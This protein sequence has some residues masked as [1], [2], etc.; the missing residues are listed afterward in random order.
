M[1]TMAI[2]NTGRATGRTNSWMDTRSLLAGRKGVRM[3]G[4]AE[5][6]TGAAIRRARRRRR[7]LGDCSIPWYWLRYDD[8]RT[9]GKG[10]RRF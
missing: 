5:I 8:G 2:K 6:C 9:L 3:A 1:S 10:R 4:T 7:T